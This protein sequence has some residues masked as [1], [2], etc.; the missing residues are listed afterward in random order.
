MGMFVNSSPMLRKSPKLPP[1]ESESKDIDIL[2]NQIPTVDIYIP[3]YNEPEEM[4]KITAIAASQ[5]FYPKDKLNVYILDDGGTYQKLN[6]P[7]KAKALAA[8]KELRGSK[9]L[10][11]NFQSTIQHAIKILVQKLVILMNL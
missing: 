8:K 2:D 6:D 9:R 1:F 11:K 3:T 5:L 4:V 10:H 7:D